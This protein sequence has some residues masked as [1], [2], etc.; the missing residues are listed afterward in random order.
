MR[1]VFSSPNG[2]GVVE[3]N[4]RTRKTLDRLAEIAGQ[5][6]AAKPGRKKKSEKSAEKA[7]TKEAS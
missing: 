4:L 7:A 2:R 3:R 1:Q 5:D 6:G